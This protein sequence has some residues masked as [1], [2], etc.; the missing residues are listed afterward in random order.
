[1]S[2]EEE[3]D[4]WNRYSR[5]LSRVVTELT[6]GEPVNQEYMSRKIAVTKKWNGLIAIDDFGAGYN[7]ETVLLDMAPDIIK[8]DMSLVQRIHE[9]P[10]RQLILNNILDFAG[11]NHITVL[12]EGVETKEELE[13]LIQCG[14]E[15]FQGTI[16]DGL[17]WKSVQSIRILS[18]KCRIL[19]RN[20]TFHRNSTGIYRMSML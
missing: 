13:F 6:E 7:S 17:R 15:L 3:A 18:G 9:D 19:P 14:V 4:L 5:Y 8:V 12:A 16:S 2:K 20:R 1:M 11:Q 10:N